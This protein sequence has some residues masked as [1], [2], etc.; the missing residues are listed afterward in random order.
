MNCF[1]AFFSSGW[2]GKQTSCAINTVSTLMTEIAEKNFNL[3]FGFT[4]KTDSHKGGVDLIPWSE[5]FLTVVFTCLLKSWCVVGTWKT[6]GNPDSLLPGEVTLFPRA[7]R[8]ANETRFITY[9]KCINP[10]ALRL[11]TISAHA[12][13]HMWKCWT[14]NQGGGG[15]GGTSWEEEPQKSPNHAADAEAVRTKSNLND[16]LSLITD[17]RKHLIPDWKWV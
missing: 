8:Q 11:F 1:V 15:G 7:A 14:K 17:S 5:R 3:I 4:L 6:R 9:D 16:C 12:K 10:N 13:L 2:T